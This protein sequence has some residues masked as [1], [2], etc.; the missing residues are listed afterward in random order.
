MIMSLKPNIVFI[1]PDGFQNNA[2]HALGNPDVITPNLDRLVRSGTTMI[3][4]YINGSNYGAVCVPSRGMML[5]GRHLFSLEGNGHDLPEGQ[6]TMPE[7]FKHAGYDTYISGHWHQDLDSFRR[8]FTHGGYVKGLVRGDGWYEGCDGHWHVPVCT[9]NPDGIYAKEDLI[10]A[11][12]P[13]E[14]FD[15]PFTR[16]KDDGVLSTE[17]FTDP[18][19]DFIENNDHE[20]PFFMLLSYVA[21]HDPFQA[22][23]EYGELYDEGALTLPPNYAPEHEFDNGE[24]RIRDEALEE[25]PRTESAVRRRLKDYYAMIT[26]LDD[27][28]GRVMTAL[29]RAGL[30]DDTI[31][32]FSADHG[33]ANGQ[34]GL[35]GKQN[36]Y[37]HSHKVPMIISGPGITA[38]AQSKS[39]CYL[40]D[41]FPTL[42]ELAGLKCPESVEGQSMAPALGNVDNPLRSQLF[43]AYR[44][45]QRGIRDDRYKLIEYM[46]DGVQ[47]T[48]L[49]DLEND[50]WEMT[51]LAGFPEHHE[52]V[53]AMRKDLQRWK[54]ELNDVKQWRSFWNGWRL[55]PTSGSCSPMFARATAERAS[56][57]NT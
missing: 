51:N 47:T 12:G 10:H 6:T 1:F 15:Q 53:T 5:T 13:I 57:V 7:A 23:T 36:C 56:P 26:H 37:D 34:H 8:S 54:T 41:L 48:Q 29:E 11:N 44:S 22:P 14:P 2:T 9:F 50:P 24:L 55:N 20:K 32:V 39:L 17:V 27:Q 16:Y 25:W 45:V 38:N 31:I 43:H 18:A 4:C 40:L 35:V 30:D 21:V 52:R 19:I 28:V 42:F 46:V 49:F 3:N 33:I